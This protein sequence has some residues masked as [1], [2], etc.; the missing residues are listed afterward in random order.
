M[1]IPLILTA[2]AL[3]TSLPVPARAQTPQVAEAHPARPEDVSSMDAIVKALYD[4]ISGPAGQARDWDRFRSLFAPGA[5]LLPT[6]KGQDGTA[7][8]RALSPDEYATMAGANLEK[9]GFFEREIGRHTDRYGSVVQLFSAYDSK[10]KAED[11]TPFARGINS[12]QLWFDGK[13]WYVATIFWEAETP[14]NQIPKK[15]LEKN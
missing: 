3:A 11:A 12:I 13:R 6:G 4:V 8:V 1:R 14:D 5:R 9:N 2:A 7:R 10:R 15:Y